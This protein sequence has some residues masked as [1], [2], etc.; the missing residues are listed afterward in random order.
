MFAGP[1][2]RSTFTP[3]KS[4]FDSPLYGLVS[5]RRSHESGNRASKK[6]WETA[7]AAHDS[8]QAGGGN[9]A[10]SQE[11]AE[12]TGNRQAPRGQSHLS[13][14]LAT[15]QE[16]LLTGTTSPHVLSVV[17]GASAAVT[18]PRSGPGF[19][20]PV[21]SVATR[22]PSPKSGW[23]TVCPGLSSRD[24]GDMVSNRNCPP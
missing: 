20:G 9:E 2:G 16:A 18:P 23:L 5:L 10:A 22:T 7:W 14:P 13:H 1:L 15:S 24:P 8:R 19:E 6:G 21:V 12:Q 3:P 4:S 11:W 17:T